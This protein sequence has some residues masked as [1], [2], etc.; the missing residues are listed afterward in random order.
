MRR[1]TL[2]NRRTKQPLCI[3]V[4]IASNFITR[5][6]GLLATRDLPPNHGLWIKPSNSIHTLGMR[7]A[8]DVVAL[9]REGTVLRFVEAVKPW[10]IVAMPRH[11]R[12]V[13]ELPA[14]HLRQHPLTIG[15]VAIPV[16]SEAGS[17]QMKK[18]QSHGSSVHPAAD[19]SLIH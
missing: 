12:S 17:K 18:R 9:D 19:S 6:V 7:F 11:T 10:R 16:Y 3:H 4:R 14:G 1:C 13:L 15:D 2:H 8:I 5:M